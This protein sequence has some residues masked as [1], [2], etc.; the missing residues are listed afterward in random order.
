MI[1]YLFSN[2]RDDEYE[3]FRTSSSGPLSELATKTFNQTLYIFLY[4]K[5]CQNR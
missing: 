4:M 3:D 2:L 5:S 1:L